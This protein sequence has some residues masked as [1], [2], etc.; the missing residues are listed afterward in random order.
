MV[1]TTS[2]ADKAGDGKKRKRGGKRGKKTGKDEPEKQVMEEAAVEEEAVEESVKEKEVEEAVEEEEEKHEEEGRERKKK[3][4]KKG[5]SEVDL[6]KHLG[7]DESSE[8]VYDLNALPLHEGVKKGFANFG[9]EKLT[10]VQARCI[11]PL[12]AGKDVLGAAKTGS[13]KTLAFLIPAL[14]M[15]L[16]GKFSPRNGTGVVVITP[17]RELAIQIHNV[18]EDLMGGLSQTRGVIIGGAN[19]RAEGEKLLKG[20]NLLIATPGRLLDHL[21]STSGFVFKNLLGLVIDEADR[22]L[23]MGF[24]EEMKEILS[25]LPANRQSML[26]SATQTTAIADLAKVSLQKPLFISVE[27]KKAVAT[28]A[29]LQQGYVICPSENRFVLLFTFLKKNLK[30]KI[31]VFFSSCAAVKFYAELLNYIDV[32]VLELHGKQKQQKRTTTFFEFSNAKSGILLCTDVAARGLDIPAVNW[33]VQ[34]DP[35]D[36]PKEYIHRVGRTARGIEGKGRA[37]LMLLPE[38]VGFLRYLKQAQIPIEEY[39]FPQK[40]VINVQAQL[41]RLIEKNYY[42]HQSARD[43]YRGYVHAYAS[44]SLKNIY[45]VYNL[46]LQK[47]AKSFGF[48]NPP[49]IDLNLSAKGGKGHKVV[50]GQQKGTTSKKGSGHTFSAA[51]PYGKRDPNDKRQFVY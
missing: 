26:F 33:I 13:G 28:V 46:D 6:V 32:P 8:V 16:K 7:L 9:F 34:F 10:E 14:D 47:V 40:K 17:T 37:L 36:E 19:R 51:N 49:K 4:A 12:L 3:K 42:L 24:E 25:I 18:A 50:A 41:E 31:I 20:V 21:K 29:G 23:D 45:N 35:S 11:P 27:D 38:E 15:L 39:E 30:K 48:S 2:V 5:K 22:L 44:H 43:A 1:T